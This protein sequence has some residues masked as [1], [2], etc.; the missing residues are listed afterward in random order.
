MY[1]VFPSVFGGCRFNKIPLKMPFKLPISPKF[2]V[3]TNRIPLENGQHGKYFEVVQCRTEL[4]QYHAPHG[5][6]VNIQHAWYVL[7]G[8]QHTTS[9]ENQIL[10]VQ[11]QAENARTLRLI[12]IRCAPDSF[13]E[14]DTVGVH[15]LK[16]LKG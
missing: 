11:Q 8:I 7:Q 9:W 3:H 4:Y 5:A 12:V 14:G 2:Y 16:R 6:K 13:A 1:R 10:R 15:K